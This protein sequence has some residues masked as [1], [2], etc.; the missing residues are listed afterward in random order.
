MPDVGL[1]RLALGGVA[2]LLLLLG[3]SATAFAAGEGSIDHVEAVDGRLK[4]LFSIATEAQADLGS[5]KV[6]VEGEKAPATAEVASSA[7]EPGAQIRR[8]A[9]LAIDVSDSMEGERFAQAKLAAKAF[10]EGVSPDVYVGVVAFAGEVTTAQEP[11]LDR[12]AASSVI[13]GLTLSRQTRLYDGILQ[14]LQA[15]GKEGQRSVLVLSDGR[16]TSDTALEDTVGAV[17]KAGVKL[18]VVA[19]AQGEAGMAPLTQLAAS[20]NG[21]I[22]TTDDPEALT[23]LFADE[24][25]ALARQILVTAELPVG[26]DKQEGTLGVSVAA[27][28]ESFSDTA[29]VTLQAVGTQGTDAP[30]PVPAPRFAVSAELMLGGL[31]LTGLGALIL[32]VGALGLLPGP[33]TSLEERVAVYASSV[34][35][36]KKAPRAAGSQRAEGIPTSAVG[37]AEKALAQNKSLTAT[38]GSRLEAAGMSLKPAEWVLLH[39]GI[40]V[41]AGFVGLLV[42]SGGLLLTVGLLL[43][44]AL[45]PWLF[46]G[47]KQRRRVNAFNARLADT[48][49]LMAGSLS[50]GLSLAQSV[51][52]VVRQGSEPITSEFKRAL[53][54]ARL[55]VEIEDALES[56]AERMDSEDFRWVVLAVRIQREV[57]GNLAE[58]LNQVSATIRERAYLRRQVKTLSAE[59]RLSAW[60]LCGLPVVVLA[61]L[62]MSRPEYLAPMVTT[63]VGWIMAGSAALLMAAGAFWMSRLVKIEV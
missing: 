43:V 52:T 33:K 60:I 16:D 35:Q 9:V 63:L 22:L 29:F 12:S 48:L 34:P 56:V 55:G 47:L 26:L 6:T 59:G 27:S 7:D 15:A 40:A 49:Q 39:A 5:V 30:R 38:I 24:A 3:S 36:T 44:G 8:T 50:A 62:L 54:E 18:D 41:G 51:D 10:L 58:V 2:A 25:E 37:F 46:L 42:S 19:L 21:T 11:T 13:D 23:Q 53:T 1:R 61:F 32:I 4:V 57:G 45:V 28:G 20:G 31:A 17:E 14:A